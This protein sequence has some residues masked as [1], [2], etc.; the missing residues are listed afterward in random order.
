MMNDQEL[1]KM[2]I[3]IGGEPI[4]VTVPFRN[5]EL[6]RNVEEEINSMFSR[7]RHS[8]PERSEKGLLAMIAYRYASYYAELKQTHMEALHKAEECL[9]LASKAPDAE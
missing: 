1:I 3:N 4:Q 8:F 9:S 5:Q 7:W 6:T 2:E